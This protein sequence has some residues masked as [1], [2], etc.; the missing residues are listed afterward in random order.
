[1]SENQYVIKQKAFSA[2]GHLCF[3]Y[4]DPKSPECSKCGCNLN[5]EEYDDD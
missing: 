3:G 5:C 1:M 2:F 4:Y